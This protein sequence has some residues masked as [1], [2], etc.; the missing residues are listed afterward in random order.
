[1]LLLCLFVVSAQAQ[2]ISRNYQDLS[3]SRVLEDLNAAS[4]KTIYFIYDELEDFTVTTSFRH[5]QIEEALRQVIGFYPIKVTYDESRI[6]VECTHKTE[7]HLKGRVIDEH[8]QPIA[9]ANI[10]L[11]NPADSSLIGGGV[12]NENG[13]FVIPTEAYRVI[14]KCSFVGY[15]TLFRP[16]EVGDIGTIILQQETYMVKGV[17]VTGDRI[18][19]KAENGHLTYNMPM[20]LEVYPADD[21]YEA[22]TR[23]PGVFESSGHL[24]FCG[25][26]V[27]LII[28]GKA[29]TLDAD[30]VV[31]RLKQMP[32]AML[33]KAEVMPSA[34][35]KYHVRGMAINI[36]TKDFSGT[37]QLSGQQ[38][39]ESRGQ[40]HLQSRQAEPRCFVRL[41]RRFGLRAGGARG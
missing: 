20:L 34:P 35:A 33:A 24:T 31:D 23:I 9:Y 30:K 36:V 11:L 17:E 19:S 8:S 28:N 27:T 4:D 25:Q 41:H 5:L 6:F 32:A 22:L 12:S 1:M 14:A 13:D 2:R 26:P 21:A 18:F 3:L 29:T 38:H 39:G 16:C 15:K 7:H 10:S 37:N 40:L